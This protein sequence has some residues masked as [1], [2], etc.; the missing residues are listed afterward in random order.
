MSSLSNYILYVKVMLI[1]VNVI[2][3]IP[4]MIIIYVNKKERDLLHLSYYIHTLPN[5]S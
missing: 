4:M 1:S 2:T 3:F 5:M